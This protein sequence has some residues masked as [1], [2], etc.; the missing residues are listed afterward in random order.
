MLA[1]RVSLAYIYLFKKI[2]YIYRRIS[3]YVR[4]FPRLQVLGSLVLYLMV[5]SLLFCGYIRDTDTAQPNVYAGFNVSELVDTWQDVGQFRAF[6]IKCR[7]LQ[8]I[9]PMKYQHYMEY[10]PNELHNVLMKRRMTDGEREIIKRIVAEQQAEILRDKAKGRRLHDYWTE[11][12][13]PLIIERKIIRAML[14]Y[15]LKHTD[16]PRV[17]ALEAYAYVLDRLRGDFTAYEQRQLSPVKLAKEK[18]L[19]NDGIHWTDWVPPKIKDR[20]YAMFTDIPHKARAK[21][22][23]PFV[24]AV[25]AHLHTKLKDRFM[26]RTEAEYERVCQE[27]NISNDQDRQDKSKLMLEAMDRV[28]SLPLTA[29]VPYTWQSAMNQGK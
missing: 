1:L 17:N 4:I 27:L 18:N 9:L 25:P 19:P 22:K 13:E 7:T 5:M 23:E 10:T 26:R 21:R 28:A 29:P 2:F 24:R 12:K 8:E 11:L 14:A 3:L 20:V 16:D 15:K 6:M